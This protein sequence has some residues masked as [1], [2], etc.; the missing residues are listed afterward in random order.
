[1]L[2]AIS[3]GGVLG[4]WGRHAISTVVSSGAFPWATF[5]VNVSGCLAI[6]ALMTMAGQLESRGGGWRLLRPFA[7]VGL[8]GGYT[9]FSAYAVEFHQLIEA[10][11]VPA[12]LGYLAGTLITALAAVWGGAEVTAWAWRRWSAMQDR[13]A[14]HAGKPTEPV[15]PAGMRASDAPLGQEAFGTETPR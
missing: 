4:A 9:T 11:A 7:G 10:G 6:G 12:G 14:R 1:M 2:V 13:H 3:C 15:E 8:L 5:L